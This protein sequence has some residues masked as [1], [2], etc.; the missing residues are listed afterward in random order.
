M[1]VEDDFACSITWSEISEHDFLISSKFAFPNL[2][3]FLGLLNVYCGFISASV[4]TIA[5]SEIP[6]VFAVDLINDGLVVNTKSNRLSS[7]VGSLCICKR[8]NSDISSIKYSCSFL[9]CVV[10]E[11][12]KH[13]LFQSMSGQLKSPHRTKCLGFDLFKSSNDCRKLFKSVMF[14]FAI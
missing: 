6:D 1:F 9:S 7:L 12:F 13:R 4:T 8:L 11:C 2:K 14:R 3:I 10:F 5:W